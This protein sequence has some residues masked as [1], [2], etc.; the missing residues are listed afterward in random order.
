MN[1]FENGTVAFRTI[2]LQQRF[3]RR[4][5][6][7]IGVPVFR[8]AIRDFYLHNSSIAIAALH[9]VLN[10]RDGKRRI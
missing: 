9:V 1:I 3:A 6:A 5:R 8:M 7:D 10:K 4:L 2:F